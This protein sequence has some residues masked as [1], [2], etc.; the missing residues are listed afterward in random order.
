[1]NPIADLLGFI[2]QKVVEFF[3][4]AGFKPGA[5][6]LSPTAYREYVELTASM[7]PDGSVAALSSE[8]AEITTPFG[9]LR[10]VIDE[11]LPDFQ[12]EIAAS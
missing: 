8:L 7:Q 10:V 9:R 5:L 6:I 1:M 12:V 3:Y 2:N 4:T 11:L